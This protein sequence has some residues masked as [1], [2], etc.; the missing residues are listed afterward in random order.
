MHPYRRSRTPGGVRTQGSIVFG[1]REGFGET[2]LWRGEDERLQDLIH[3]FVF[4]LGGRG[5]E[6]RVLGR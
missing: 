3:A 4:S 1:L 6:G 5:G 2:D